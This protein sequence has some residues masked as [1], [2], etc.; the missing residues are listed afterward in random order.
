MFEKF[1]GEAI[2]PEFLQHEVTKENLLESYKSYKKEAFITHAKELREY[3]GSGSSKRVAQI[4]K[5]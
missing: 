2:H 1:K 4:I 5:S 3:L